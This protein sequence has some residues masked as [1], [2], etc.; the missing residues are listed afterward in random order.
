ML[1]NL[2]KKLP[3][4]KDFRK[5]KGKR[6]QLTIVIIIMII[7]NMLGFMSY[8][9][10][11]RFTKY[12]QKQLCSLLKVTSGK[13]PSYS[14]IR[15]VALGINNEELISQFNQWGIEL[16]NSDEIGEYFAIDG[17]SL[18]NTVTE[19]FSE[20]QNFVIFSSLFDSANGLVLKIKS[21]ENKKTSEIKETQ[22]LI[23]DVAIT[24]KTFSFDALHCQKETIRKI[25]EGNNHYLIAVKKNQRNLYNSL[26][27]LMAETPVKTV[28]IQQDN[29]HGRKIKRQVSV[30]DNYQELPKQI[31]DKFQRI[32]NII[33]VERSGIRGKKEYEETVYYISSKSETATEVGKK[34]RN[35]WGIE[36]K[37]HWV[38]DV[39]MEEDTSLIKNQ[40]AAI[41]ISVIKSIGINFFRLLK[42]ESITDGRTWLGANLSGFFAFLK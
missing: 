18:R 11:G 19:V 41:N 20:K 14:T 12:Y 21:Y 39:V 32:K 1:N 36:N 2:I 17:K 30:W 31:R 10:L 27:K 24:N 28:D 42:F 4:I 23:S 9:A 29:S 33:K 15:R 34:I 25:I 16:M 26:E 35:H 40:K 22:D 8:R 5:D 38:K 7:G 13:L 6:H 3:N 37:L